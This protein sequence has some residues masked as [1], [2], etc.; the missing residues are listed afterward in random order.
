LGLGRGA[1]RLLDDLVLAR[2]ATARERQNEGHTSRSRQPRQHPHP[3]IDHRHRS[4]E[5]APGMMAEVSARV[6]A[7]ERPADHA[8]LKALGA[9]H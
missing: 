4:K 6:E 7:G 3:I 2:L 1:F 8:S 5:Q 9:A